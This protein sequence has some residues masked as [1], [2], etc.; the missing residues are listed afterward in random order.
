MG[1]STVFLWPFSI[2]MLNYQRVCRS[3]PFSSIPIHP[4]PI[5]LEYVELWSSGF[6]GG[7]HQ[8]DGVDIPMSSWLFD[9]LERPDAARMIWGYLKFWIWNPMNPMVSHGILCFKTCWNCKTRASPG[10]VG[11]NMVS[12]RHLSWR[13]CVQGI[14][15]S[16]RSSSTFHLFSGSS[17]PGAGSFAHKN[18]I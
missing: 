16:V 10:F 12:L 11:H 3:H 14:S 4:H 6:L 2:A 9:G 5:C 8:P 18:W 17:W 13:G 15:S 7:N 1:K